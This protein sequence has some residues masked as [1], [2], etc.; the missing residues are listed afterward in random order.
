MG[1]YERA[2]QWLEAIALARSQLGESGAALA[3]DL[4]AR[5][6]EH[7]QAKGRSQQAARWCAHSLLSVVR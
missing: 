3:A 5:Y 4:T 6:A 7:L 1:V 2:G